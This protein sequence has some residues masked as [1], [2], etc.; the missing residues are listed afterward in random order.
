M[1]HLLV[2]A[3]SF[4]TANK[5]PARSTDLPS[6]QSVFTRSANVI[7]PSPSRGRSPKR[8]LWWSREWIGISFICGNLLVSAENH[9]TM[10][11][12]KALRL[13]VESMMARTV[14]I[15]VTDFKQASPNIHT[16][17]RQEG[18]VWWLPLV[19]RLNLKSSFGRPR[20]RWERIEVDLEV[21]RCECVD[22][23]H[24]A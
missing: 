15:E 3:R 12:R 1:A 7:L 11:G 22:V 21:I 4:S 2:S 10:K 13:T 6:R 17:S 9:F 24:S 18:L 19:R 14:N 8:C 23:I 20:H 5:Y 16:T